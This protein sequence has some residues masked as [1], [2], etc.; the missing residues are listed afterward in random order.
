MGH[1]WRN[2]WSYFLYPASVVTYSQLKTM[3][4]KR[5]VQLFDVREPHEYQEGRIL[6][7]VHMPRK[8][9][10]SCKTAFSIF[11]G[12]FLSFFFVLGNFSGRG[13]RVFEAAPR[14][15]SAAVQREGPCKR[16]PQHCV[17]LQERQQEFQG[18]FC[19][20]TAGF[21]QVTD[22][23]SVIIWLSVQ[24]MS[25]WMERPKFLWTLWPLIVI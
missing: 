19:S 11:F 4:S 8:F 5:D 15:V 22:P 1:I 13:G 18:S 3:L 12:N 16:W 7:A 14:P 6:D 10:P 2:I 23:V 9:Y 20:P 21:S 25:F 17:L 24:L